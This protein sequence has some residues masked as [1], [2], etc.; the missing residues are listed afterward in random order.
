[1]WS[2]ITFGLIACLLPNVHFVNSAALVSNLTQNQTNGVHH[3]V[4]VVVMSKFDNR[5]RCFDSR[6]S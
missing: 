4:L 1:M 6:N 3:I 5:I 2:T